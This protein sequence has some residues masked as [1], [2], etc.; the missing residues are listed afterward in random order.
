MDWENVNLTLDIV[1]RLADTMVT[2][3]NNYTA[4]H[5]EICATLR[6]SKIEWVTK[7]KP[8]EQLVKFNKNLDADGFVAD[9]SAHTKVLS[10]TYQIKLQT[11]PGDSIFEA[12]ITHHLKDDRLDLKIADISRVNKYGAQAR[13]IENTYPNLRKYCY[14][15]T[16]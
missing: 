14:C 8:S 2:T 1:T 3:I 5:R 15:L 7:M 4:D 11:V 13:C 9:L 10:H 12:S 6:V 16:D